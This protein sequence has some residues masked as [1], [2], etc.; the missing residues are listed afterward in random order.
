[1]S[2]CNNGVPISGGTGLNVN[3]DVNFNGYRITGLGN[4][5]DNQDAA[6]KFYVDAAV[7]G[8]PP[9]DLSQLEQK[10]QNQTATPNNTN[11]QGVL[12][13]NGQPIGSST[14]LDEAYNNGDGSIQ[15]TSGP[16]PVLIK[17][18]DDNQAGFSITDTIGNKN[19]SLFGSGLISCTNQ[20]VDQN[21][22]S[23]S[24][25]QVSGDG[26]FSIQK[27]TNGTR[28]FYQAN[29]SPPFIQITTNS[30][31]PDLEISQF[32]VAVNRNITPIQ[33][34]TL[35]IG[36]SNN[37][38]LDVWALN[39][40]FNN[41][42][43]TGN[44]Q[45]NGTGTIQMQQVG[46]IQIQNTGTLSLQPTG[47][48]TLKTCAI[49]GTLDMSN[50]TINNLATPVLQSQAATKN[51]VDQQIT[52]NQPDLSTLNNKTQNINESETDATKTTMTQDLILS[53]GLITTRARLSQS[54]STVSPFNGTKG[55]QIEVGPDPITITEL[56]VDINTWIDPASN[57]DCGIWE[58]GNATALYLGNILKISAQG[59]VA[60]TTVVPPLQCNPG[61]KYVVGFRSNGDAGD[62]S[63]TPSTGQG[64]TIIGGQL[65]ANN[66]LFVYPG[67]DQNDGRALF[68]NFQ[69][70]LSNKKTL[71][72]REVL[73]N[74][75]KAATINQLS[76]YTAQWGGNNTNI[77]SSD[78]YE[79][80]ATASIA[81]RG[82][83]DERTNFILPRG[84]YVSA[85]SF[86]K[87]NNGIA[88][89]KLNYT[90]GSTDFV[91]NGNS[92]VVNITGLKL[93]AGDF[94]NIQI[95]PTT[96]VNASGRSMY[97]MYFSQLDENAPP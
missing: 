73:I 69:Y 46:A 23:N 51:Y 84:A 27:I 70:E 93:N 12:T 21:I 48:L 37:K 79:L 60:R 19:A 82:A 31:I 15:I 4:P 28:L 59:G 7:S 38:F 94:I 1:M 85:I 3:D 34:N 77:L 18:F 41:I 78:Y 33:Q 67:N 76:G 25:S 80:S 24:Y 10:T 91:C 56:L 86:S 65:S 81:D 9:I 44:I 89:Y 72:C 17:S 64:I 54:I 62:S 61:G 11:F 42:T 96:S 43:T 16:K 39:G 47:I 66:G 90:G 36:A 63:T 20:I 32:G 50:N 26:T 22:E 49:L 58:L 53:G 88:G 55:F 92:G 2:R 83:P 57:K 87:Q 75:I 40:N 6:T 35:N 8:I 74:D 95:N 52:A 68:G 97:I 5:I 29:F 13:V 14:T 71:D 30:T 45:F